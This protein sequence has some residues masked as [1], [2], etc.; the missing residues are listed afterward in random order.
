MMESGHKSSQLII[1]HYLSPALNLKADAEEYFHIGLD[2]N[3]LVQ[4]EAKTA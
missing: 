2:E 3:K 4:F 1:D